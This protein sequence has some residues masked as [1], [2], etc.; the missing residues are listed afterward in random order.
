MKVIKSASVYMFGELVSRA[1]PFLLMPYLSRTLGSQGYGE[2][3]FYQAWISLTIIAVS[4]AQEAAIIRYVYFYG[5]RSLGVI[6]GAG[7]YYSA[8]STVLLCLVGW[9]VNSEFVIL[10]AL[11]SLVQTV[12]KIELTVRQ[13]KKEYYQYVVIQIIISILSVAITILIIEYISPSALGRVSALI[14]AYGIVSLFLV[15]MTRRDSFFYSVRKYRLAY[16]YL[17]SYCSPLLVN[18]TASFFKGQFDRILIED[19]YSLSELGVYAIGY[20]IASI[21]FIVSFVLYRALEPIYFQ[22]LKSGLTLP[23]INRKVTV[24]GWMVF[25]PYL[26][27]LLLPEKLYVMVL[28]DGFS[29]VSLYVEPF[30]LA[31]SINSLYFVYSAYLSYYGK[32]KLLAFLSMISIAFY[33]IFLFYFSNK[34]MKLMPYATVVSNVFLLV[35]A[36]IVVNRINGK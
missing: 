36:V 21:I 1:M 12:I 16:L 9:L 18:N 25:L 3:S 4:Y 8:L 19:K 17:I 11:C 24:Y 28:G 27:F 31:F 22:K 13:A 2:L 35:S 20:Q 34:A 7:Y 26:L 10:V 32:T 14:I 30:V 29:N 23:E 5:H 15:V 33:L 6:L